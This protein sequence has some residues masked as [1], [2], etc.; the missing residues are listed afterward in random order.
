MTFVAITDI[1]D[2]T[3]EKEMKRFKTNPT[4]FNDFREMLEKMGDKID[5]VTV[6]VPDHSHAVA[7]AAAMKLARH[8]SVKSH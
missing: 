6:S 8:V 5:A 3:I 7:A 1:D 2:K 4:K